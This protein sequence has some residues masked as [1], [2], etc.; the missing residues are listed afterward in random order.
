VLPAR[1]AALALQPVG[2]FAAP[3]YATAPPGDSRLFVVEQGGTIRIV[4]NGATLAQPFLDISA[5]TTPTG[6][7]GLLSMAFDP[8][9]AHNGLFYVDYTGDGTDSGGTIGDIHV[10]QFHVSANRNV[11]DRA[12]RQNVFIVHRPSTAAGNHNGGQLQFGPDGELYVSVGD[13]GTGGATAQDPANLNG[14][15]LRADP[16]PGAVPQVWSSGL[17]NPFRF[18]FDHLDGA[19]TIGDVGEGTREE[20]D[21][22]PLSAGS[23]RGLNF[24]W[25]CRE[26]FIAGPASCTGAFTDPVFD[27]PHADP[28]GGAA[29]GDAI[30]GGFVYR[31]SDIPALAGRYVYADL[32]AGVL[33]TISLGLP[34]AGGDQGELDIGAQ[35]HGFG[36]DSRCELYVAAGSTVSKIVSAPGAPPSGGGCAKA[37]LS[38]KL[39]AAKK[40]V[41][42]GKKAKLTATV[43]PCLV[44][45]ETVQL[46]RGKKK[47]MTARL[48]PDCRAKFKSKIRHRTKFRAQL[49]AG[50]AHLAVG[51]KKIKI[52][53][54]H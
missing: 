3:I 19:L 35:P 4:E 53:L 14:K 12:S 27:Y 11:A 6:E 54:K 31:G 1:A 20:I 41:R 25:P 43:E 39:K 21:Y 16:H 33:R 38:L 2:T 17:R 46:K 36:Q 26:G 32:M 8:G 30:I 40:R 34:R 49:P 29:F 37:A 48:G 23:G 47:P 24:G 45:G 44:G 52:R 22:S 13:G 5:L 10:D 28:G 51:S 9:Y 42:R 7:R 15:L 18:S 50:D